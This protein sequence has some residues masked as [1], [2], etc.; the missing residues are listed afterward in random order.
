MRRPGT[1][2]GLFLLA[3]LLWWVFET[4]RLPSGVEAKGP[5]DWMPWV[6]LAGSVVSLLTGIVTLSLKLIEARQKRA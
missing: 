1:I 5:S 3:L 6:S 4:T 2:V